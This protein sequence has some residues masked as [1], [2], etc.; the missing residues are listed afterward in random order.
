MRKIFVAE[1]EGIGEDLVAMSRAVE[2]AIDAAGRALLERDIALAESVIAAD[3]EIDA[4]ERALDERCVLLIAQQAPVARDLRVVVSA[5]RMSASLE[6]MGDLARHVADIA[7][8]RY[9]HLAVPE[10]LIGTFAEMHRDAVR[11]AEQTT[12]LL[13]TRDIEL[14]AQIEADDDHLDRLHQDTFTAMLDPAWQGTAQDT[15]NVALCGR[16]YERFGDHAVSVARR[17]VFLVT[18][19][20]ADERGVSQV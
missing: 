19:E 4:M 16:Y 17:V 6:R 20:F 3:Q 13:E 1:L 12:V 8:R 14:A 5:L 9:P 10:S 7:R 2:S 15:L 18:G 11:V